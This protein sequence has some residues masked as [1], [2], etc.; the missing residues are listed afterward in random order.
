FSIGYSNDMLWHDPNL[1]EGLPVKNALFIV[2][3]GEARLVADPPVSLKSIPDWKDDSVT[4][5]NGVAAVRKHKGN[6]RFTY[7]LSVAPVRWYHLSVSIRTKDVTGT[8]EIKVLAGERSL[9]YQNLG[10]QRTQDWKEHHVVFN[11][12]DNQQVVLYFGV[13]GDAD[14]ELAWKDWKVE[15]AGLTNVLRRPGTP[16]I[17]SGYVE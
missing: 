10:A 15:E 11:S 13:W 16:L 1:A 2:K 9:Q 12:L 14:G 17:V 6:A 4:L 5:D 7:P 3:H 8:P